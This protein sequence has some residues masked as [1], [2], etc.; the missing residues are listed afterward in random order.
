MQLNGTNYLIPTD[1][2]L[3]GDRDVEF[4][5][6]PLERVMAA[7]QGAKRLRLVVIDACRDNPFASQMRHSIAT[8][9]ISRGLN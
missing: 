8:R 5:T 6:I 1:A 9:S 7:V 4:E 3:A 2:T